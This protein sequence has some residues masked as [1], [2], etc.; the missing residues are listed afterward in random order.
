ML[1]REHNLR[2]VEA[3]VQEYESGRTTG[4]GFVH[5]LVTT[6]HA[7][8]VA[9]ALAMVAARER[10][11]LSEAPDPLSFPARFESDDPERE[12]IRSVLGGYKLLREGLLGWWDGWVDPETP[13]ADDGTQLVAWLLHPSAAV[14]AAAAVALTKLGRNGPDAFDALVERLGDEDHRVRSWS[15]WALAS[16]GD[17]RA[18]APLMHQIEREP[19]DHR[20]ALA[21]ALVALGERS[22][23]VARALRPTFASPSADVQGAAALMATQLGPSA[24]CLLDRLLDPVQDS[25][26]VALRARALAEIGGADERVEP[27]LTVLL[28]ATD[29]EQRDRSWALC[30]VLARYG[31]SAAPP[32]IRALERGAWDAAEALGRVG[33]APGVVAALIADVAAR[34]SRYA[35]IVALGRMGD[36]GAPAVEA[37][38]AVCERPDDPRADV[39]ATALGELGACARGA[40]SVVARRLW[41]SWK[42]RNV[43]PG[44]RPGERQRLS[45]WPSNRRALA[46]FGEAAV[47]CCVE[48]LSGDDVDAVEVAAMVLGA[49]GPAAAPQLPLLVGLMAIPA[50]RLRMAQVLGDVGHPSPLVVEALRDGLRDESRWVRCESAKALATLGPGA[51]DAVPDLALACG[52]V[53]PVVRFAAMSALGAMGPAAGG[54][55]EA[56]ITALRRDDGAVMIH[57]PVL[58]RERAAWALGAVGHASPEVIDALTEAAVGESGLSEEATCALCRLHGEGASPVTREEAAPWAYGG[59]SRMIPFELNEPDVTA[60]SLDAVALPR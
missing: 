31:A 51:A 19:P 57:G 13:D 38:I 52:D 2:A 53:A 40:A 5:E 58:L 54:Q 4:Y 36:A 18:V 42:G 35:S 10:E 34:P 20:P 26:A 37:L 9:A 6:V 27:A 25:P 23:R 33:P 45:D 55:V 21:W 60:R 44:K 8:T 50:L 7:S 1:N 32:L 49:I 39:A 17:R 56:L 41:A 15:A 47:P 11:M 16:L 22:E 29:H 48:A 43:R 59:G 24:A 30:D 14:R 28:D 12:D 3:I 46:S